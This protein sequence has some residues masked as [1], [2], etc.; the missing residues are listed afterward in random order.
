MPDRDDND[1][2]PGIVP[3]GE[4]TLAKHET[5]LFR[6]GLNDLSQLGEKEKP[7]V[8]II[9]D[10]GFP[11]GLMERVLTEN[12]YKVRCA[13]HLWPKKDE[14]FE[15]PIELARIFQ[16]QVVMVRFIPDIL[17]MAFSPYQTSGISLSK[18]LSDLLP[19]GKIVLSTELPGGELERLREG[20]YDFEIWC[21]WSFV[22]EELLEKMK[23]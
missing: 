17:A 15:D 21:P 11:L 19:Q 12:G 13:R 10:S 5:T 2:L 18:Q 1:S 20:G 16:P 3:S 22:E 7:R 4:A 8:L 14:P 6:R 23:S 9:G